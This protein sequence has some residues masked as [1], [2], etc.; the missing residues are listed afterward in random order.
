MLARRR[1]GTANVHESFSDV[2]LLMLATFVFLLVAIIITA[3]M[4]EG[5]NSPLLKQNNADMAETIKSLQAENER[6]YAEREQQYTVDAEEQIDE[7][8]KM[9]GLDSASGRKAF[10]VF[11]NGLK[12]I[13]GDDIHLV[14]DATG[15]MHGAATFMVP[16]LR[17]IVIRTGKKMAALTWFSD[18]TSETYTGSM[19]E[20]FDS[21][22]NGAP[23]FGSDETIGAAFTRV[24]EMSPVPGAY[25]MLGDEPS[26]DDIYY[27]KIEA[28]VFPIAIG[29]SDPNTHWEYGQLAEKT[30]GKLLQLRFE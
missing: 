26:D 18:N 23:F 11:I 16:L 27:D 29:R 9:V 25:I 28:P 24:G 2:A 20:V 7:V 21:F 17:V 10:D 14:I 15:S 5:D 19:G 30:G 6:L 3:R 12:D 1:R 4:Q 13:P 8:L 22:M